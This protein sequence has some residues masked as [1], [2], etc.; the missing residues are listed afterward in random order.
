MKPLTETT[1]LPIVNTDIDEGDVPNFMFKGDK[2]YGIAS[3]DC[4]Y[5]LV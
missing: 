2:D 1:N 5:I 4:N 3:D